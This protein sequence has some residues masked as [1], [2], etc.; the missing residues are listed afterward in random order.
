MMTPGQEDVEIPIRVSKFEKLKRGRLP[1]N[2]SS[3]CDEESVWE[4]DE[5]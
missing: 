1:R 4:I 3:P 2:W 5:R